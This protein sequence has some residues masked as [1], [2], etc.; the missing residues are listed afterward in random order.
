MF[1]NGNQ[2]GEKP[3]LG[4]HQ[5]FLV[6]QLFLF[7]SS[8]K[9]GISNL[10]FQVINAI[11]NSYFTEKNKVTKISYSHCFWRSPL[12]PPKNKQFSLKL[13]W[14]FQNSLQIAEVN[15]YI[16]IPLCLL[17]KKLPCSNFFFLIPDFWTG[18]H[19]TRRRRSLQV[20]SLGWKDT[21][22]RQQNC[23]QGNFSEYV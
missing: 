6:T 19:R 2:Q 20:C 16:S 10:V 4:F 8:Q 17:R 7:L 11:V 9:C 14:T 23:S 18:C 13:D 22:F 3:T 5:V 1:S 21:N 15:C 12:P